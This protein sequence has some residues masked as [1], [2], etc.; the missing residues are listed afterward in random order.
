MKR[1]AAVLFYLLDTSCDERP[2][3]NG[4]GE[5]NDDYIAQSL[6]R[7]I[8]ALPEAV[9]SEKCAVIIFFEVFQKC[10]SVAARPKAG[11]R[12]QLDIILL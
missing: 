7:D 12:E 6:A 10:A 1:I 5:P 11:L 8:D 9:C 3:G 2:V 4:K